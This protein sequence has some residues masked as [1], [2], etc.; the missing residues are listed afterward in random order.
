MNVLRCLSLVVAATMLS[1]CSFLMGQEDTSRVDAVTQDELTERKRIYRAVSSAVQ[2]NDTKR[3]SSL[4]ATLLASRGRTPSGN[5]L[6]GVFH[7]A[8]QFEIEKGMK[9]ETGCVSPREPLVRK[10]LASD[11]DSPAAII[12]AAHHEIRRGWCHRGGGHAN[13]VTDAGWK[14]FYGFA[15]AGHQLLVENHAVAS[16]DPE[17]YAIMVDAYR[18]LNMSRSRLNSL[19]DEATD[20]EPYYLRT[21]FNASHS[22][23]PQWGGSLEELDSFAR[24]AAWRTRRSDGMG[25]YYRIYWYLGECNCSAEKLRGDREDTLEAMRDIY[26]RYPVPFNASH[27]QQV[28]CEAGDRDEALH[29]MRALHPEALGD[30]DFV[31]MLAKCVHDAV[32]WASR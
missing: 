28:S 5:W 9:R 21:Y 6:S 15:G 18:A 11:P 2:A 3:L 24:Y 27:M 7:S 22:Y 26:E 16:V 31:A 23:L 30:G 19:L 8:I 14:N 10:W 29:Y 12:T 4:A 20:R 25:F 13:T 17:F 32:F 1:G